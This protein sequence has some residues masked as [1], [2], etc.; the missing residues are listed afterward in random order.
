MAKR[1]TL[2]RTIAVLLLALVSTAVLASAEVKQYLLVTENSGT[3]TSFALSESPVITLDGGMLTVES[4]SQTI[5][6]AIA[7][8][9]DYK[10]VTKEDIPTAVDKVEAKA[11]LSLAEGKACVTGLAP[12][13]KVGVYTVD[14][15]SVATAKA[16]AD[17]TA[18]VDLG[19]LGNG[20]VYILRTPSATYKV[21]NK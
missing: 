18:T 17:G 13:A 1:K 10:F 11:V 4:A 2:L 14:G 19:A 16:G 20:R 5:S 15:V 9:K 8:V 3:E 12:G 6:V 21:F 7:E